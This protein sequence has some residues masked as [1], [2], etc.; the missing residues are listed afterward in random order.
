MGCFATAGDSGLCYLGGEKTR[1]GV[2]LKWSGKKRQATAS[3]P[4]KRFHAWLDKLLI[5]MLV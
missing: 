1:T 5:L 4:I 3:R 2:R